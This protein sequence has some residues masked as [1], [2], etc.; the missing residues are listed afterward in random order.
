[1]KNRRFP[2]GYEMQCGKI[3]ICKAESNILAEIFNSYIN[4]SNL[5]ENSD[6][7]TSRRV[8]YL[9][10][11]CGWNKSR[12]KR[13]IEDK[14]YLGD[15]K[16]PQ[17]IQEEIFNK[18]NSIKQ[19]RRTTK[20]YVVTAENK[21]VVY[22]T[23]CAECGAPLYHITDTRYAESESWCCK[24]DKCRLNI[25]LTIS[26]LLKHITDLLNEVIANQ[27]L[28]QYSEDEISSEPSV[29]IMRIENEIERLLEQSNFDNDKLQNLIL[30]CAEKKYSFDKSTR[31]ITDRLKADFEKSSPLSAFSMELFEKSVSAVLINKRG[32]VSIK[33]KNGNIIGKEN[34]NGCTDY[35]SAQKGYHNTAEAGI[36]G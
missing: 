20:N 1:M 24:T 25:K 9:P 32:S 6:S 19:S 16:Y 28:I 14:R 27:E 34:R 30:E 7:L 21:P 4:G 10:D 17:I 3:Q 31:H 23:R 15:E 2:Y 26:D 33:L 35:A 5:R 12:I 22:L 29:E 8:E 13:I 18:A 36:L 11:E